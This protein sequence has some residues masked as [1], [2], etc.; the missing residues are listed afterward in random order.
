MFD[1]PS[2]FAP[3]TAGY[4]R[5]VV[6]IE[7]GAPVEAAESIRVLMASDVHRLE[8]RADN[9]VWVTDGQRR[10]QAY[11]SSLHI[12]VRGAALLLNGTRMA[13]EQMTLR[14]G[15]HDLKLWLPGPNG[16]LPVPDDKSALRISGAVQ[17]VK[18]GKG[19]LVINHVDLEEYVK[20]V[21]PAE[22]NS[23]WHPEM[24]KAQ[25]VA[26]ACSPSALGLAC[27]V[28]D[29]QQ[30][31]DAFEQVCRRFGGLELLEQVQR[32]A[33]H[34]ITII[35]TTITIIITMTGIPPTM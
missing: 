16:A 19:L 22:V 11:K 6:K 26:A 18:K 29:S 8:V 3:D 2:S 14:A 7:M 10:S 13:G 34:A 5:R 24:L 15:E 20:G 4:I 12:E 28:T 17:L 27:D 31:R 35:M 32:V 33:P 25:A 9:V 21:V 23:A 1:Y 30:V